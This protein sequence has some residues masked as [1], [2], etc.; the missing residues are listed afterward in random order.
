ML[1]VGNKSFVLKDVQDLQQIAQLTGK[2]GINRTDKYALY[3]TDLGSM[4]NVGDKTYFVFGDSF[5]ERPEGMTGGGGSLWRSN[6]MAY[7]TDNNPA[8]GI[9]FDG[10]I[11]DEIG[12][13]KEL[14]PS[15]KLDFAEMTTIPTHGLYANGAMYL[16]YMS[17]NHWGD[18]G[19]WDANFAGVSKSTDNG[20][21]WSVLEDLKWPGDSNFIQVS[22][23]L[24]ESKDKDKPSYI[25][26]WCVPSGRF[27]GVKLMRVQETELEQL[28][29]YE[30]FAGLDQE[31]PVWSSDLSQAQLVVDDT[32]GE[33]SV[34]W[35]PY[36][37]RWIMTYLKE[38]KGV[39]I[40]EGLTPWGP[41]NDPI[42][43]V[44]A[45]EYPGL[46][47][48]F[49]NDRYLS[50]DGKTIYFGLSLWDPY[51]VFWYKASLQK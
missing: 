12:L 47:A 43:L 26:F 48:P 49:M 40:R 22:P 6:V 46:Y 28:D 21:T 41:W 20:E 30:Y 18:P 44:P 8:D 33:L 39:V 14:I 15:Q 17:V 13:A 50:E 45:S 4:F 34:I 7:T 31:K 37:G 2:D 29:R 24:I 42:D 51:N 27:G 1:S 23:Y 5:G 3:G 11:T 35:N 38:G 19:K 25:Y 9:I 32:V 16:Y 10:M 36:L